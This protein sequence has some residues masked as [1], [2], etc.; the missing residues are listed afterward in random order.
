MQTPPRKALCPVL[1]WGRKANLSATFFTHVLLLFTFLTR[2]CWSF[3]EQDGA[4]Q[5]GDG[6]SFSSKL[7]WF[8]DFFFPLQGWWAAAFIQTLFVSPPRWL[9]L[10]KVKNQSPLPPS[11]SA[12]RRNHPSFSRTVGLFLKCLHFGCTSSFIRPWLGLKQ[13]FSFYLFSCLH[14]KLRWLSQNQ[15]LMSTV[16][17]SLFWFLCRREWWSSTFLPRSGSEITPAVLPLLFLTSYW[18]A[19]RVDDLR[20]PGIS[21]IPQEVKPACLSARQ[22][23]IWHESLTRTGHL[24]IRT[25]AHTLFTRC[26]AGLQQAEG[27]K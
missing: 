20:L 1:L 16:C 22:T 26:A 24:L 11:S 12:P 2:N 19:I 4:P 10:I 23:L 13:N 3:L 17:G 14:T 25:Q 15:V 27:C 7:S 21:G 9:S 18:A 6:A 5:S 8:I